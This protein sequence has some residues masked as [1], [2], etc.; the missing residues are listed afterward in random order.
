MLERIQQECIAGVVYS[1]LVLSFAALP[2]AFR[3]LLVGDGMGAG[4]FLT[5]AAL[6]LG[7]AWTVNRQLRPALTLTQRF[8][9]WTQ[10]RVVA[11]A[12]TTVSLLA[13]GAILF[14]AQ[15]P[16]Y[17][18]IQRSVCDRVLGVWV[19]G[20]CG[21]LLLSVIAWTGLRCTVDLR[22]QNHE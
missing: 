19:Q 1:N 16:A 11:L 15:F 7:I 22:G 3:C 8:C 5:F 20:V 6:C 21:W 13:C 18:M 2:V 9:A 12:V 17:L 14:V 4:V 10:P